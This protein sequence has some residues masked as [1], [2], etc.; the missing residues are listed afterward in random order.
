M[1]SE[2]PV[3]G[4]LALLLWVCGSTAHYNKSTWWSGGGL[5]TSWQLGSKESEEGPGSLQG[6][7]LGYLPSFHLPKVLL[8]PSS[9]TGLGS[10]E[11]I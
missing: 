2:V 4:H 5:F 9:T 10:L 11:D 7:A 3:H 8:P 1:V 6:H